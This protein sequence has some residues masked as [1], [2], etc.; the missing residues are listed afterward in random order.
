MKLA[1]AL[2]ALAS[3]SGNGS[4][5]NLITAELV[6]QPLQYMKDGEVNGCGLRIMGGS[7]SGG[8]RPLFADASVNFYVAG[9]TLV[10][11]AMFEV[12]NQQSGRASPRRIP[13]QSGWLKA[14]ASSATPVLGNAMK[15]ED[16]ASLLYGTEF[17][18]ALAVVEAHLDNQPI[19]IGVRR[20]DATTETIYAGRI[21]LEPSEREQF[22]GCWET[23]VQKMGQ[24]ARR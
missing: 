22:V 20:V 10:K 12:T 23:L 11:V 13:V 8:G 16:G 17:A 5:Q 9:H 18:P 7:P 2:L 24:A 19:Q 4:A 14:P 3:L 1:L 21:R 6:G 15:G